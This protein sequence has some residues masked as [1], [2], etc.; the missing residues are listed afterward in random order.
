MRISYSAA[1]AW[2]S[3]RAASIFSRF[4]GVSAGF[5]ARPPGTSMSTRAASNQ[6]R[7]IKTPPTGISRCTSW[8]GFGESVFQKVGDFFESEGSVNE[9]VLGEDF[10]PA[11]DASRP[12]RLS[13]I[14]QLD[15]F[16]RDH[17]CGGKLPL[18]LRGVCAASLDQQEHFGVGPFYK[19]KQCAVDNPLLRDGIAVNRLGKQSQCCFAAR[20][21]LLGA[22]EVLRKLLELH[23][24]LG[25]AG[26][27]SRNLG[28]VHEAHSWLARL[29]HRCPVKLGAERPFRQRMELVGHV[30]VW[31]EPLEE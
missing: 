5:C 24:P 3:L 4:A 9:F 22:A 10:F 31:R 29:P 7:L 25:F 15:F 16:R 17:S 13:P 6:N 23:E 19:G 8:L 1:A 12:D 30:G 28:H 14:A 26:G 2:V 21:I 11:Q 18:S 20:G 27:R